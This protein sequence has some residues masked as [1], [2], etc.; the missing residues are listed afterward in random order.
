MYIWL[1]IPVDIPKPV[2]KVRRNEIPDEAKRRRRHQLPE[3]VRRQIAESAGKPG[4]R[5]EHHPSRHGNGVHRP[6]LSE[7]RHQNHDIERYPDAMNDEGHKYKNELIPF[8]K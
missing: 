7:A 8:T 3:A 1:L 6:H 4:R 2:R 5:P